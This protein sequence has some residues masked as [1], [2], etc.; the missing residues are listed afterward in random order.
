MR[1]VDAYDLASLAQVEVF[2][3]QNLPVVL[4]QLIFA[5]LLVL[6]QLIRL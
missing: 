1:Q 3:A 2:L 4:H 5:N 6:E